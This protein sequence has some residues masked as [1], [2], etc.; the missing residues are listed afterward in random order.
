MAITT[1]VYGGGPFYPGTGSVL[2][3]LKYTNFSTI[4]CWAIH[5]HSNADL[6][7]NGTLIVSGG[8]YVGDPSWPQEL[9]DL[10]NGGAVNRILFSIGGW[11]TNDFY[12]IAD[13]IKAHGTGADSPLYQAFAS[14]HNA[15]PTID[16]MDMDDEG[17]YDHDT[18]VAFSQMLAEIGY[19]EVTFCPYTSI[20]FWQ[21]CLETLEKTNPG[22]V[23][24]FNLQ[25]YAGG[26]GNLNDL[27]PWIDAVKC[28]LPANSNP[29]EFIVPGL[30]C[31][32]G[33][34]CSAGMS[35]QEIETQF[36]AYKT[37]GIRGGF[38]WL[39]DDIIKCGNDP[40]S[41]ADAIIQGLS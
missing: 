18:I 28:V 10:K 30:W 39:Y 27:Q 21:G 31:K 5:V 41:Y 40:K 33:D 26:A 23:T 13:L 11:E 6:Y 2:G 38:I 14:L 7:F 20:S 19:K 16:G 12:H 4:V 9:Q 34:G 3:N 8:K 25:C 24:A 35:A 29:A 1:A 15:I 37:Q 22:F 32:H 36:N 17:N